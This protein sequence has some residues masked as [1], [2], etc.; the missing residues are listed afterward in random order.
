MRKLA[1]CYPGDMAT[2]YVSPFHSM[3][4]IATPPD[5]EV[6]WFRGKGWC[7]A[8]RRTHAC[9]QA[10]EWGAEL[11]AQ[12]DIDQ[13]YDPDVL[14]RLVARFDQG[15]RIIAAMVPMRGYIE[16]SKLPPFARLAW[17][18]T[19][20]G[21]DF[22]PVDASEGEV[23]EVDFP[24]SACALFAVEDLKKLPQPWYFFEYDTK[25][26]RLVKGEDGL[27]FIR[28]KKHAGVLSY[29]DTTIRVRHAHVFEIDETFPRRFADWADGDGDPTMCA[30]KEK[31]A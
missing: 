30:F 22:E 10:I 26:Y 20:G 12:L 5:C 21:Q 15:Y 17:R 31:S 8:R 9:E 1:V 24:T 23:V 4:N 27:F 11:I 29:V 2:V 3:V 19:N 6:R 13:T 28:M 16:E 25:T 7:Q 14:C 18:S